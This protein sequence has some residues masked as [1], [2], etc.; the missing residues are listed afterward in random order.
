MRYALVV[1]LASGLLIGAAPRVHACGHCE[2]DKIAATYDHVVVSAARRNGQTVVFAELRGAIGPVSRLGSW[3]RQQAEA[4][5]GVVRGTVRISLEP[6]ALS[7]A[8]NRQAVSA[9]LR[10]IDQKLARRGLS[11]SLIEAQ[12]APRARVSAR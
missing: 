11:L 6:A 10:A 4:S 1:I 2:E 5:T 12:A 9:A 3:I 8:C 7:F